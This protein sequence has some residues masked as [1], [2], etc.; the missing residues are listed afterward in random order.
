MCV[1]TRS[2]LI[3]VTEEAAQSALR[4]LVA[5]HACYVRHCDIER[6][7]MLLLPGNRIVWVD[8]DYAKTPEFGPK[9]MAIGGRIPKGVRCRQDLLWE[10]G[11]TWALFYTELV[12]HRSLR[13]HRCIQFIFL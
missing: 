11:E 3:T 9:P 12:R 2:G 10:V 1:A 8:F 4:A 6:R 13:L 7:N 5:I